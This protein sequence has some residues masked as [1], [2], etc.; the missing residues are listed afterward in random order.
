[1]LAAGPRPEPAF[2]RFHRLCPNARDASGG[3]F[4]ADN[5]H[6]DLDMADTYNGQVFQI[7]RKQFP[8]CGET[9]CLARIRGREPFLLLGQPGKKFVKRS[10]LNGR[11]SFRMRSCSRAPRM[12][13]AASPPKNG[14]IGERPFRSGKAGHRRRPKAS[15]QTLCL[16]AILFFSGLK[17]NGKNLPVFDQK[18]TPNFSLTER[19]MMPSGWLKKGLMRPVTRRI[20]LWISPCRPPRLHMLVCHP[21]RY[22]SLVVN[23]CKQIA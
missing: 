13:P 17:I 15:R 9:F 2:L 18:K 23:H 10:F 5:E 19:K 21:F 22:L 4:P 1:M 20:L 3:V 12:S 14:T 8:K 16:M 6:V 7:F 11:I